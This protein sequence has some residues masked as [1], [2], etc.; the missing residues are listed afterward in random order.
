MSIKKSEKIHSPIISLQDLIY[1]IKQ[2]FEETT[3]K[4]ESS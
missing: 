2:Y 4:Q 3:L 1:K